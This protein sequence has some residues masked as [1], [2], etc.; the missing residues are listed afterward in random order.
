[1]AV[2]GVCAEVG[3]A[4]HAVI[5]KAI[6]AGGETRSITPDAVGSGKEP[7]RVGATTLISEMGSI[8]VVLTGGRQLPVSPNKQTFSVFAGLSQKCRER[9]SSPDRSSVD[10]A[11]RTNDLSRRECALW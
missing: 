10:A 2:V 8:R 4:V 6:F 7:G 1:M 3:A 11:M 9:M 5:K